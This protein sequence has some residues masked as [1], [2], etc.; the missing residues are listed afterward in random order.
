MSAISVIFPVFFLL[1]LGGHARRRAWISHE[2]NEG[3]KRIALD[4]FF[5]F[6]IYQVMVET[7]L[8]KAV[9]LQIIFLIFIWMLVYFLGGKLS[10]ILPE[11]FREI[12]PFLCLTCEGGAVALPLYISVVG[13][14]F[15]ANLIP[16]DIAGILINFIFV[17]VILMN[18]SIGERKILPFAKKIFTSSFILAVL[19]GMVM[20]ASGLHQAI[21]QNAG[22]KAIFD[23]TMDALTVPI[24]S[25]ILFSLGYSMRLHKGV[26][27][28]LFTLAGI[29][30]F[31]CGIIILLFFFVFKEQM[32]D[33]IFS[34]GVILYFLCP[35][36][37][38]VPLQI[39]GLLQ[40]EEQEEFVS[41]F[42]SLFLVIALVAYTLLVLFYP[43][44]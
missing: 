38:P 33:K 24:G 15:T 27:S 30:L 6:L 40:K 44:V 4:I 22:L 32:Q 3:V 35:T 9:F 12:G 42:I 28:S 5:P 21:M 29:R 16:F 10:K 19:F 18:K 17:P 2:Q 20:N 41:A 13:K 7:N 39:K 34:F 11:N 26:L 36:G 37:F 43:P 31:F 8:E 25:L 1:F 14:T 23:N